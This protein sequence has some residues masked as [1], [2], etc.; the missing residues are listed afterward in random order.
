ML[1]KTHIATAV[2]LVAGGAF[3]SLACGSSEP[4][5]V[6]TSPVP[7]ATSATTPSP[8]PAATAATPA[9]TASASASATETAS[10]TATE[11]PTEEA[12][13][14]D[15][16][17]LAAELA[18]VALAPVLEEFGES[19]ARLTAHTFPL[20]LAD[21]RGAL[22][23]VVTNGP[24]PFYEDE[25]GNGVNFFHF[26]ALYRRDADGSWSGP[27]AELT[28]ET[29]PQ[30][31][32]VVVVLDP[33]PR[34]GSE[35]AVL[36]AVRGPT[37]AHAGTL[38][39]LLVEGES[40]TT[41]VSHISARPNAG[42]LADLDGDGLVEVILNTSD[43]YV[44]CYACAVEEKREQ[45]HRWDR[46]GWWPVELQAPDDLS[47]DLASRAERVVSLA[48]ANLWRDA[49]ALAI[50]TSRR[51]PEHEGLRWLSIVVNR[52][53]T[54]RLGHAGTPGQP[55]LTNVLAGE[56][57]AAFAL[58]RALPAA[59]AFALDGP[60]ILG[61]AAETD[62]ATMAVFLH[63]YTALALTE[64][65]QDPS[66]HAVRALALALA[67]PD[68]LAGAREAVG[69]ALRL[70]PGETFLQEAKAYL[71]SVE[72]APGLPAEAPGPEAL[73]DR[74][75]PSYFE[76]YTL[77]T[78][79]RGQR[80]RAL[81]QRLARVRGLGFQDPGRY[82]DVYDE[83]TRDA[84]L[85]LQV[86]AGLPPTGVVDGPTWEALEAALAR[87]TPPE[88]PAPAT[89]PRPTV[90]HTAHG[91]A[92][93]PVVYLTFD[94]GPHPTWTPQMLE[95]LA[96]HGVNATFFVL[97]QS[98]QAYPEL[99]SRLVDAGHDAENH[100]FDHASLDKVD[101]AT[102]IAEVRDTDAAIHAAAG[103]RVDPISC[104]RPPY[105]A[106]DAQT[107][108][109]A[110]ELGKTLTLW[111]VDPQDWRRPGADQIAEHLIAHARPGA[112][113]LMHD[114]GGERSQT[115]AALDRVLRELSARG[116]TFALLCQ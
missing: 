73:L 47:G 116:Y 108:A 84:V 64:R 30:R 87:E 17:V 106:F 14:E 72:R 37:G 105:G 82:Y 44:F 1:A 59:E 89:T 24:Q 85:K 96:R 57:G 43:P 25:E 10:A 46:N 7:E 55:L 90:A 63:D 104:L 23:V 94:D 81:Q 113:L 86:E 112:I 5:P 99:A 40:L 65:P 21:E 66:I 22:W 51:A 26:V 79:D 77:G 58:M 8:E 71:E 56:Y 38:D 114:G 54:L 83:A 13:A 95:V 107:S 49:A 102:F 41:V 4:A 34:G 6:G 93:E 111:N 20:G 52:M 15:E 62:L 19:A 45:V 88:A 68:D 2:L 101:R 35:P 74:P 109:L 39:M 67:S 28:L 78:G 42:Q 75:D 31:T 69:E 91:D 60:L 70:A 48:A 97:G 98:V 115:V 110:A 29:A 3:A 32:E 18:V 53:A 11:A 103:E 12:P 16:A 76:E 27:L 100:T 50:E 36:I 61:T 33:G 80:V 9:A 92:G